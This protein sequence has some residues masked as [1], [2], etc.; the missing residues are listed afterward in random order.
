MKGIKTLLTGILAATMIMGSALNVSAADIIIDRHDTYSADATG[1]Q[2][3]TVYKILSASINGDAYAY[4]V[5]SETKANIL[6]ETG[7]FDTSRVTDSYYNV[8]Y[9]KDTKNKTAKELDALGAEIAEALRDN[10]SVFAI[11]NNEFESTGEK[12][13]ISV[14]DPGYYI[15]TSSI[16]STLIAQTLGDT[17]EITEK[18]TYPGV[19]K[20]QKEADKIDAEY[21]NDDVNVKVGDIIDYKIAV[22]VPA[23]AVTTS[24]KKIKVTDQMTKGLELVDGSIA[25]T[26]DGIALADS[27]Y[28][29]KETSETKFVI[30]IEADD[31]TKGKTIDITFQAKIT[32]E[33]LVDTGKQNEVI[34]KYDNYEQK[35]YVNYKTYKTGAHKYDGASND[36]LKG[37]KF[38]LSVGAEDD[39][40]PFTVSYNAD[41]GYYYYDENSTSSEVVTGADGQII[42]RGVDADKTYWLT[43]TEALPGYNMLT[44]AVQLTVTELDSAD[45]LTAL[46]EI[47]NNKGTLLPSTGGM[48][49]T[50]F[51][52]VGGVL[53]VAGVAYFILRRKADAQ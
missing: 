22:T 6:K 21:A 28:A 16:G 23:A 24:E 30:D 5:D 50:I 49:T 29:I 37:V 31:N 12:T 52:I 13:T 1:E 26:V 9:K 32:A 3:Y 18:N 15:I 43:E 44:E 34:L 33:A 48:G 17:V 53:V 4:Y 19:D 7:L 10:L 42:I 46:A 47:P 51:Y 11:E 41:G 38:E 45:A 2:T 14:A 8:N 27:S 35:D 25:L 40:T 36:P 39:K 20:T